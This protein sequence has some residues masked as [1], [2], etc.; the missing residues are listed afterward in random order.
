M[1]F[2]WFRRRRRRRIQAEPFP[3]AWRADIEQNVRLYAFLD[4]PQRTKLHGIVQ[5]LVAEKYWEGCLGLE[6]TDEIRVTVAAQAALL[7]LAF[8]EHYFEGVLTVLVYPGNYAAPERKQLP[9]GVV[10]ENLSHRE[11]EAW[12]RGP[13][14]LSWSNVVSDGRGEEPSRNLVLHEFAHVL[15]MENGD[16]DGAP[17]FESKAQSQRWHQVMTEEY[18][19]LQGWLERGR[20]PLLDPYAATNPAEFF[21]V[22]TECF[23]E[24][25][26]ELQREHP[27]LYEVLSTYYRQDPAARQLNQSSVTTTQ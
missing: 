1:I 17:V 12:Q 6:M 11:G 19:R 21:A 25:P 9:G 15:D 2:S 8:D 18:E 13:V 3:D 23:F 10:I 7:V 16:T 26:V 4:A 5:V 20:R 27:P 22:A 24:Q 14:V